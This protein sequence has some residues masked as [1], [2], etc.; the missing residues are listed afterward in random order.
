MAELISSWFPPLTMPVV[1]TTISQVM[2]VFPE[3]ALDEFDIANEKIQGYILHESDIVRGLVNYA[4]QSMQQ[5]DVAANLSSFGIDAVGYTDL[6]WNPDGIP[7]LPGVADT[8]FPMNPGVDFNIDMTTRVLTV[9]PEFHLKVLQYWNQLNGA[10]AKSILDI[11][12]PIEFTILGGVLNGQKQRVF[13]YNTNVFN[14]EAQQLFLRQYSGVDPFIQRLCALLVALDMIKFWIKPLYMM[15]NNA[16]IAGTVFADVDKLP[17]W[18]DMQKRLENAIKD[19][20]DAIKKWGL[21]DGRVGDGRGM[22]P[23]NPAL[24][25]SIYVGTAVRGTTTDSPTE[26]S[27]FMGWDDPFLFERPDRTSA[28]GDTMFGYTGRGF[29]AW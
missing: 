13:L 8:S 16:N 29:K 19:M 5:N 26:Y 24:L 12:K 15:D 11:N 9:R 17:G 23:E 20:M 14:D 21:R 2:Q 10:A 3:P 4:Y 18:D 27:P 1:L 28:L 7:V 6:R 25:R 22:N